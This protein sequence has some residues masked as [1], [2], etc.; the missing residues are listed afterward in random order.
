M[1]TTSN[2]KISTALLI[3]GGFFAIATIILFAT[4]VWPTNESKYRIVTDGISYYVEENFYG[5]WRNYT[6]WQFKTYAE[7]RKELDMLLENDIRKEVEK[8]MREKQ[9]PTWRVVETPP[10]PVPCPSP[11]PQPK[12]IFGATSNGLI[13]GGTPSPTPAPVTWT[14][15]DGK[16]NRLSI[17][18]ETPTP[19]PAP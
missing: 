5:R 16:G 11:T 18:Q 15:F 6:S 17:Q 13:I 7:A 12:L 2:S 3:I 10:D 4:S 1:N 9:K 14:I 19:T 8:Q